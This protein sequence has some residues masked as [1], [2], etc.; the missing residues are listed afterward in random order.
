MKSKFIYLIC[1]LSVL[2]TGFSL[3]LKKC[4]PNDA[5][6]VMS[7]NFGN[8]NSKSNGLD[9]LK[10]IK[11]LINENS[12][13]YY[14]GDGYEQACQLVSIKDIL[15]KPSEFGIDLNSQAYIYQKNS[16]L[17]SGKTYL[18]KLSNESV[19]ETK[20]TT[21]ECSKSKAFITKQT[22]N[23]K[24][25]MSEK[26]VIGINKGVAFIFV[27]DNNSFELEEEGDG[28]MENSDYYYYGYRKR[29]NDNTYKDSI[30]E[31]EVAAYRVKTDSLLYI[32][33]N[34]SGTEEY[35]QMVEA[36]TEIDPEIIERAKLRLKERQEEEL[37]KKIEKLTGDFQT[38][39]A[40]KS[41]S[42]ASDRNFSRI[43]K[44]N[45]DVIIFFNNPMTYLGKILN[46]FSRRSNRYNKNEPRPAATTI[47]TSNISAAYVLNFDKGLV[48]FK[49]LNSFGDEAFKMLK[50]AYD[51]K[52]D[53]N[54]LKY[55]EGTNLMAYLSST[56][57]TKEVV[58][59]YEKCYFEILGNAYF[60]KY[61]INI[62]PTIEL[63][64]AMLDKELL[65]GTC[66]DRKLFAINGFIET[67][68]SY[69]SYEYDEDFQSKEVTKE[70]IVK[71]PRM[72]LVLGIDN[73]ENALKLFRI[74]SKFS[75]FTKVK[76]NV[77]LASASRDM[78]MNLYIVMTEDAFILTNDAVLALEKQTGYPK[79]KQI[80]K[81]EQK[82][83]LSHNMTMRIFTDKLFKAI[84]ENYPSE[85]G[86]MK[87]ISDIATN[88]GDFIFYDN[89]M[90]DNLYITEGTLSLTNSS[91]NSLGILL[92]LFNRL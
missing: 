35:S 41:L 74:I 40:E 47:Y 45:N 32:K 88:L 28:E 89:E 30:Y 67:K 44:D 6:Y 55:V 48:R 78:Q 39:L 65:F 10:Y 27:N 62:P 20:M 22:D 69:K 86:E 71:T 73:K 51:K 18:F 79:D 43:D 49:T 82:F 37:R 2:Q 19:F 56:F 7:I 53:P 17:Y 38:I 52:P 57:N 14:Y 11:S 66:T 31:A 80:Q 61:D 15:E 87:R 92:K 16:Q 84:N 72:V 33:A 85:S 70:K 9:Y 1:L 4:I 64:W 63:F 75:A 90:S 58:N 68:I 26:Y 23:G 42:I 46:P 8:L 12:Y 60:S 34:Q 50:K 21:N 81:E 5:T 13:D 54:L 25:I 29:Y 59:F 91:E 76:D 83:I 36:Y 3:D 77:I 24:I